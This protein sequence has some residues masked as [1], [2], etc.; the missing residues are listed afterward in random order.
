MRKVIAILIALAATSATAAEKQKPVVIP[1]GD[2]VIGRCVGVHDGDSMTL[3]VDT[4]AGPRQSKIRLDAIDAP[5]LGQPFSNRSKQALSGMVFDKSCQVESRGPD[6]YG[7]TIGRVAVD[8][9]DVNAAMLEAGMAW[10]FDKNDDRQSMADR[11]Q[12][13]CKAS[14]GLW[15]DAMPI[16]PWE[17]RKMSKAERAPHREPATAK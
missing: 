9:K 4:P 1:E 5:E 17:W 8:G 14:V 3:L 6:K 11:H 16:P 10:H 15:A 12:A 13:A 7:R 2:T